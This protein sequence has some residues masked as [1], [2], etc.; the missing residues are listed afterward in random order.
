MASAPPRPSY[1]TAPTLKFSGRAAI[2]DRAIASPRQSW[3]PEARRTS[4]TAPT[5]ERAGRHRPDRHGCDAALVRQEG[6]S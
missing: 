2:I 3:L 4:V 6:N 5:A 1:S